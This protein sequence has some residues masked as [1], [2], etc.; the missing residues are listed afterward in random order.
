MKYLFAMTASGVFIAI[1]GAL[2]WAF[3]ESFINVAV[4][5]LIGVSGG[6]FAELFTKEEID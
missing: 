6:F 3:N 2:A 4:V 1:I 5:F